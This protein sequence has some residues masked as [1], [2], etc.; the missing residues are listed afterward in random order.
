MKETKIYW[1]VYGRNIARDT[2]SF[3]QKFD[4]YD[5]ALSI[6][7][8]PYFNYDEKS[9]TEHIDSEEIIMQECFETYD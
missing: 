9:L 5:L 1:E 6:Y 7:N 8:N 3:Y 4:N 2:E